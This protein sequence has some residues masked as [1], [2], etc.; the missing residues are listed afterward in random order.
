MTRGRIAT[1]RYRELLNSLQKKRVEKERY[2]SRNFKEVG[3]PS[4][5]VLTRKKDDEI[6]KQEL[7]VQCFFFS[8]LSQNQAL[9]A[10]LQTTK[11]II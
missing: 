1:G 8:C 11:L 3:G 5:A 4:T 7:V 10:A 2:V 6:G 9:R